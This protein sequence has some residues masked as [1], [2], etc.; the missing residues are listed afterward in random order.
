VPCRK[1][2]V[3]CERDFIKRKNAASETQSGNLQ[4]LLSYCRRAYERKRNA[5][6]SFE[7]EFKNLNIQVGN[8]INGLIVK[9]LDRTKIMAVYK[10][11]S[12]VGQISLI[13]ENEACG[14]FD[15][16]PVNFFY[17]HVNYHKNTKKASIK[18]LDQKC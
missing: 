17:N 18:K 12:G 8:K 6:T 7:A 9:T 14:W 10:V 3:C 15:Q 1:F 13:H 5:E 11:P 16:I 4:R 2:F